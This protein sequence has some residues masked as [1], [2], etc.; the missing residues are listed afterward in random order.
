MLLTQFY[1]QWV[2]ACLAYYSVVIVKSVFIN[3]KCESSSSCSQLY[4]LCEGL[5]EALLQDLRLSH[6]SI[7]QWLQTVNTSVSS[8]K[9]EPGSPQ[10]PAEYPRNHN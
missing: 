4:K 7:S 10:H 6:P 9:P 8:L 2:N 1:L 5:F 3:I